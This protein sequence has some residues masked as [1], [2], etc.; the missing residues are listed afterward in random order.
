[1]KLLSI[2][3]TLLFLLQPRTVQS[4]P[5][6]CLR[7]TLEALTKDL[8]KT[9]REQRTKELV[10]K[11]DQAPGP[12][13]LVDTPE[14][15]RLARAHANA[16]SKLLVV[17]A[18]SNP[19]PAVARLD[20]APTKVTVFVALPKNLAEARKVFGAERLKKTG[21][22]KASAIQAAHA[23][24]KRKLDALSKMKKA[25]P[26]EIH[27][28]PTSDLAASRLRKA[29]PDEMII[30]LAHVDAL[31]EGGHGL[32]MPNG[33]AV[34]LSGVKSPGH[35][36]A[37]GCCTAN[38]SDIA[39]GPVVATTE[40]IDSAVA[41]DLIYDAVVQLAGCT[42]C[43]EDLVTQPTPKRLTMRDA[44]LRAQGKAPF[45]VALAA[46]A[47]LITPADGE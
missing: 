29:Q 44:L 12:V 46:T 25:V 15:V 36:W 19:N 8:D 39:K 26:V 9:V 6:G 38:V 1:M 45:I 4:C 41:T 27:Y 42:T 34:A 31:K 43:V 13:V 22:D 18:T 21:L 40:A 20:Q 47:V 24:V 32:I 28:A 5:K 2:A 14:D 17:A 23:D 10:A 3:F 33:S 30:V 35:F 11:I 7:D 16:K 37:I